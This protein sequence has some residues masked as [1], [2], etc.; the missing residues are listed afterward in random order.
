VKEPGCDY[1]EPTSRPKM[2]REDGGRLLR[3]PIKFR[4]RFIRTR[5]TV[6]DDPLRT[7]AEF[8]EQIRVYVL[9]ASYYINI[10]YRRCRGIT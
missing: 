6:R 5:V 4:G 9:R 10:R 3:A 8:L 7:R 1:G 2:E